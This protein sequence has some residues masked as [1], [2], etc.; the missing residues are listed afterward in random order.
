M[1]DITKV[2]H[3]AAVAHICSVGPHAV[4]AGSRTEA[5]QRKEVV[6]VEALPVA[7]VEEVEGVS[8][9]FKLY[10]LRP[11]D[12]EDF[13]QRS[14]CPVER[15]AAAGIS[16]HVPVDFLKINDIARVSG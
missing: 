11:T 14:I 4:G 16:G 2:Q 12:G 6:G 3:L 1:L 13:L 15:T 7:V 10:A 9:E 5:Q 8:L